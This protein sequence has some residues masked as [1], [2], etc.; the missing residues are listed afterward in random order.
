MWMGERHELDLMETKS[1]QILCR[2]T[3]KD[4]FRNEQVRRRFGVREKMS[5]KEYRKILTSFGRVDC[6][7]REWLTKIVYD[8]W[9]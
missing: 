5:N 8:L 6:M 3:R 4:R 7:G 9:G 2:V 1:L